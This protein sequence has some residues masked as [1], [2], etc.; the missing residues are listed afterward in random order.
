M[1]SYCIYDINGVLL[2]I[3]NNIPIKNILE[4]I[5]ITNDLGYFEN[6][7]SMY[8]DIFKEVA[9]V[10]I[11]QKNVVTNKLF[12]TLIEY[13]EDNYSDP[14]M[15]LKTLS[16][17][18]SLSDKYIS[19]FFKEKTGCNFSEY[20]ENLRLNKAIELMRDTNLTINEIRERVGYTT[21]NTFYKA[22]RR[23]FGISPSVWIELNRGAGA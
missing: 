3:S 10:A 8:Q 20:V 13:I 16:S 5:T 7:I 9:E 22:F 6:M 18:F 15:S 2:R 19:F 12:K 23:K 17:E 4:K 1:M 21:S 14:S 11:N